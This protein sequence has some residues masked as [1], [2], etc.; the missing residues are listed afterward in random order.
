MNTEKETGIRIVG[1]CGSLR[2]LSYTR[3]AVKL[4]LSGAEAV[5]AQ[6]ELIDLREYQLIFCGEVEDE[7]RYPP[8]IFKLRK[9]V[10]QSQGIILG[11]PEYHGSFSGVLKNAMDLMGFDEFQGKVMGLVGVSGGSMGALNALTALRTVGRQLHAWIIPQQASI[12]Q[13]SEAFDK[14]GNLQDKD[15]ESRVIGVGREVARFAYLLSSQQVQEFLR[16]WEAAP[17]NPGGEK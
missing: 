4:A 13:A 12:P 11:T 10:R 2:H 8:D 15:L 9:K 7:T 14:N 6:T 1:I 17:V 16:L 5:G 3:L